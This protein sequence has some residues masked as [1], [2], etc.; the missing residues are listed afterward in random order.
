MR[1]VWKKFVQKHKGS[2]STELKLKTYFLVWIGFCFPHPIYFM[3]YL[4]EY[5]MTLFSLKVP[6]A[7]ARQ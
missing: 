3:I 2:F 4:N 1:R 7:G 5:L 6:K